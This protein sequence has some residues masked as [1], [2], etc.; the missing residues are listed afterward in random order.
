[1]IEGAAIAT[2][3]PA[4][5]E[6]AAGHLVVS[7]GR[8]T[9]VGTGAAP[10]ADVPDGARHVDGSGCLLTPGLVN[11][12]HHF[13]QWLTR[14][15]APD[16]DL[17]TWLTALYP[18][19][20]LVDAEMEHAA[21][22]GS[23]V[24]LVASGCTTAMDHQYVFPHGAGDLLAA[25]IEAAAQVGVR[26]HPA[27]GSM[28]LGRSAGGLPSDDV[29][30]DTDAALAATEEAIR[31]HHDPSFG[32]MCRV[33]VAPCSPFSVTPELLR[34]A[35]DLARRSGVRLHTHLAETAE[36]D[37]YCREHLGCTPTEYAASLGWLGDDVWVAHGVHLDAGAIAR[38]AATGTGVAHCP[39]SNGR[40]GS[41]IA[42]VPELLAAGVPVGLGVDGTASNESGQ[43]GTELRA[44]LLTARARGG[45][46]ALS[47]RQVLAL[48]TMGGARCLG[49]TD[50][51]GSLEVGKLADV[52]LWRLDTAAHAGIADP[53]AALTLGSLPP[54]ELLLV[55]GRAV[56]E[57]GELRT[58]DTD[59]VARAVHAASTRLRER[60]AAAL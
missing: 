6:H 7:G 34:G 45:P 42:P 20:A 4:G 55:G 1:M 26:F 15:H 31:R 24:A 50:E 23:L 8:I 58:V 33:V 10:R 54:I 56:A 51:I 35:A 14:G 36:E 60:A 19:W 46:A 40:L 37:V 39:S 44:A 41:G 12:H 49:R 30:E 9:A 38:F 21:A 57:A 18:L 52:A 47:T 13:S 27:R 48:A 11:T 22:L 3:D 28:D 25:E 53:V 29:V 16:A 59:G 43:L 5:T 2:V 17:F 32:S